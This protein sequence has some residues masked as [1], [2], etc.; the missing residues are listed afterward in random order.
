MGF[1]TSLIIIQNPDNFSDTQLLLETLCCGNYKYVEDTCFD[2][3]MYPRD[4]SLNIAYHNGNIIIADDYMLTDKFI[5]PQLHGV[6]KALM[7]L[8]PK[9][10]ILSIMCHSVVNSHGYA[11]LKNGKKLR[12]KAL[13]ADEFYFDEGE[14]L[15]EER[16]IYER[17]E[18]KDGKRVWANEY[19]LDELFLED[20]LMEDFA[21]E[22]GARLLGER[23]DCMDDDFLDEPYFK[24]YKK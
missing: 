9:S 14:W 10:E 20:Q 19:D 21:F 5:S 24:K 7:A 11:L 16:A 15:D 6:E 17:S 8:F 12:A 2:E 13:D 22:V 23:V 4:E 18:I 3:C 1:K